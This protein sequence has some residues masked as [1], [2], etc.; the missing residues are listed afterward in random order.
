GGR[1]SVTARSTAEGIEF[2][3]ADTGIGMTAEHIA[4]ALTPFG[5]VAN[6]LTRDHDGTGL[7]LPLVKSLAELHG[8]ALRIESV[9]GAGTTAR[10]VFPARRTVAPR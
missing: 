3:V 1:I 6:E 9:L 10:V 4:V 8:A 7:G 5:Q 2:A